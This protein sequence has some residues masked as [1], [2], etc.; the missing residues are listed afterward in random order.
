MWQVSTKVLKL[1]MSYPLLLLS[2]D[3][4]RSLVLEQL[5]DR[6]RFGFI[7]W[8]LLLVG[9]LLREHSPITHF[10]PALLS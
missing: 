3:A 7:R 5:L 4:Q 1:Y 2:A 9:M 8:L 6:S 10:D